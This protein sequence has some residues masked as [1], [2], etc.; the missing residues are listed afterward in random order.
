MFVIIKEMAGCSYHLENK[1]ITFKGGC[2]M[3]EISKDDFNAIINKYSGFKQAIEDGFIVV[4]NDKDQKKESKAVD[5]SLQNIKNKQDMDI[6]RNK[7]A[8]NVKLQ[9]GER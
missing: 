2:F 9:E 8:N 5:D 1:T 3:N 7:K 4:S 6:N